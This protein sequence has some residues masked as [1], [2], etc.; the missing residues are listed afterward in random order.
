MALPEMV[1]LWSILLFVISRDMCNVGEF[2]KIINKILR[3]K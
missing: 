3:R 1:A 2:I